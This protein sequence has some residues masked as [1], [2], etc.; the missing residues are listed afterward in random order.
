MQDVIEISDDE[1]NQLT[2]AKKV[3]SVKR[4][5][6]VKKIDKPVVDKTAETLSGVVAVLTK[7]SED[8]GSPQQD[9][10][11]LI[12]SLIEIQNNQQEIL[13]SL[14]K[15]PAQ[16]KE[17]EFALERSQTGRIKKISAREI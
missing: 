15:I 13:S 8:K 17:W 14:S 4:T 11:P 2:I 16:S 6:P 7:L 9:L 12:Q 3:K 10:T 5:L 1:F